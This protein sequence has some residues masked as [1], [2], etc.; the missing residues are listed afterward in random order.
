MIYGYCRC[1]T[2]KQKESRQIENILRAYPSARIFSESFTGRKIDRPVWTKIK[3]S[4]REGDTV[5]FDEV[6][7]MSRNAEDGFALYEELYNSGIELVFLKEPHI[8]TSVYRTALQNTVKETGTAVDYII[9]GINEYLMVLV[10]EQIRLAFVQAQKEVDF[11][12]M[13]TSE[14]MKKAMEIGH[15][16]GHKVGSTYETK[17]AK[18]CKEIILKH[19]VSFGGSLADNDVI[20]LCGCSRNSYYKYKAELSVV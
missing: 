16:P 10:K 9:K 6:S 15:I 7:R 5:V 19:S 18:L 17:K 4:L 8:N 3:N 14:G 1:S 20:T 2:Q 11:L 13:R 12:S